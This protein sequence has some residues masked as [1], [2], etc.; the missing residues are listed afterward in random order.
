MRRSSTDESKRRLRAAILPTALLLNGCV[1]EEPWFG[2]DVELIRHNEWS[3]ASESIEAF[4]EH[5]PGSIEC[6]PGSLVAGDS[7]F[8]ISTDACNYVFVEQPLLVALEPGDTLTVVTGHLQLFD[9]A[10]PASGHIA[11]VVDHQVLWERQIHIPAQ[12]DIFQEEIVITR[13]IPAGAPIALHLHNHGQNE[14]RFYD[15]TLHPLR[16]ELR[17]LRRSPPE[18]NDAARPVA[19]TT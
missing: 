13:E 7:V 8:D 10:G 3:P 18:R 9:P 6:E 17:A 12:P 19:P 1:E 11:L 15:L 14:W 5:V 2:A 16:R 4:P